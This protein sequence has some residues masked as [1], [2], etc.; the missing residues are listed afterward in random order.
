MI[1]PIL[2]EDAIE[3]VKVHYHELKTA[4]QIQKVP[5]F[6]C[7]IGNFP[8]YLTYITDQIVSNIKH[9]TFIE[10]QK[11]TTDSVLSIIKNSLYKTDDV[12]LWLERNKF[13]PDFYN[14]QNDLRH[15]LS[16]NVALTFIFIALR[17]A[18]K[19]WAIASKKL[20]SSLHVQYNKQQSPQ[21]QDFIEDDLLIQ[22][23]NNPQLSQPA[24]HTTS[25]IAASSSKIKPQLLPEYLH[26]CKIGFYHEL[27]QSYFWTMRLGFEKIFLTSLHQIPELIFSPINLV[28][29]LADQYTHF[30]DLIY[31]LSEHFPTYAMHRMIYSGYLL[32]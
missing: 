14:F 10:L 21:E 24:H 18:V 13:S 8:E 23:I 4:L 16:V 19:G 9:P 17:E 5:L 28:Y 6:F 1:Q 20:E 22:H 11:N 3:I 27:K 29:K 30:S 31:L 2:E 7:Y 25:S 32:E 26:L 15:I 12:H